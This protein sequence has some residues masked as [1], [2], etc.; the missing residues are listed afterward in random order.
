MP[1]SDDTVAQLRDVAH[2]PIIS[3][4]FTENSFEDESGIH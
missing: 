4:V 3:F 2:G 1:P